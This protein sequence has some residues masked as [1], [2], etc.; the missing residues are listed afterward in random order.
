MNDIFFILIFFIGF[1]CGIGVIFSINFLLPKNSK[2]SG[3]EE[4]EI[5]SLKQHMESI[6]LSLQ[7][8]NL[9]QNRLENTLVRG[10]SQQQGSWGEFV[11][12]NILDGAGLREGYEYET[13]KSFRDENG[14][15]QKPDIIVRMPG[16]RDIVIDSKVPLSAWHDF[17]NT[18]DDNQKKLFL[19]K[20]LDSIK[21]F[22]R[23]LGKDD[24]AS[25]YQINSIDSVLMFIPIEPAL[26]T[27]YNE[28]DDLIEKAWQKKIIIVG[29]STLPFLLKAVENMWRID[30]QSKT[31]KD[32][33]ATA[34]EIYDKAV[35]VYDSFNTVNQSL[36]KARLKMDEAKSRLQDGPGSLT[37]KIEKMKTL[38]RL[39]TKKQLPEDS[40]N[41]ID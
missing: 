23:D 7:N 15:L 20:F 8:F 32:I 24:Y 13:Q 5:V 38:G 18:N 29:P 40:G 28:A 31:I 3:N 16:N 39:N 6:Q 10:G 2:Q 34:S 30:K 12:K 14:D 33:A 4:S 37:K 11:L 26:L 35:N 17:S 41:A 22:V 36:D 1:F 25:L 19:K 27:L 9:A 21:S